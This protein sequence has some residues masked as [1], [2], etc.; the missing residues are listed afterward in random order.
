MRLRAARCEGQVIQPRLIDLLAELPRPAK[1]AVAILADVLSCVLAMAFA[2][3]LRL[4]F[5]PAPSRPL[6]AATLASIVLTV[7]IFWAMQ[8]YRA[9]FRHVGSASLAMLGA[10][11][12]L[13][14]VPFAGIFTFYGIAGVPRTIGLLQPIV[15]LLFVIGNR[16]LAVNVF[17]FGKRRARATGG[18]ANALIY[19]AGSAGR[20][21]ASAIHQSDEMILKGFVD[22]S[23]K[24]IGQRIDDR[25]VFDSR[26]LAQVV[27]RRGITHILLAVP[28]ASRRRRKEIMESLRGVPVKVQTLPGV[29]DL[30]QGRVEVSDLH[31]VSIED[32]LG[33]GR[34]SPDQALLERNI[35]GKTVMV[36]GA[37]GSI[38]S[39]LCRQALNFGP[40]RLVLVDHDE[41]SLYTIDRELA[42][43]IAAGSE[44]AALEPVL[45]SVCDAERMASVM[46][47]YRPHIVFHAA[48]YKHVPLVESNPVE[49][50]RNNVLGTR[51]LAEAAEA[52]GVPHF[53][54]ISTDKAVRPTSVMGAT[55]RAAE[56]V[57][58][59]LAAEGGQTR[60]AMVRF[61]NVLGSR[62]SVV[63]LFRQQIQEGGP[64]TVTHRSMTRYFMLIPEAAQ[65]VIQAGAMAEGGEVFLL[66]MGEPVRIY[67]LARNMIELSGL[68][69]RDERAPDGEI[70]IREIGLR[71]GEKMYEE[72]LIDS[73]A[74]PTAHPLIMQA[75]EE[76]LPWNQ[77]GPALARL[78]TAIAAQD[79]PATVAI[80][81]EMVRE[82][83]DP[84][85][86]AAAE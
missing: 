62:G 4:G 74:Q 86:K 3:Y 8:I 67:D 21:L 61:G 75:R 66:D 14:V 16:A 40:A 10:A 37:G 46:A 5:L 80:L 81:G 83:G 30:A 71:P 59:G 82:Y 12:A 28:S 60:F 7:S 58:Q 31:D 35:L 49:G 23:P 36:T 38:G 69:V 39:E 2:L 76:Y 17:R 13:Y 70:E 50:I 42:E 79:E 63:P 9:L 15:L 48:A 64:V 52:A 57:L 18:K 26:A 20:Q 73:S 33:R 43:R 85:L 56:I 65:L 41:F 55:K 29:M 6:V 68:S 44:G 32:L 24:L 25:P 54:L 47:L 45:A 19:G 27:S 11:M 77:V 51:R 53:V 84:E 78:E 34:V 72:L 1:K 22:D